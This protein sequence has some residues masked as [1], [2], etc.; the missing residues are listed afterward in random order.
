LIPATVEG[1]IYANSM[2]ILDLAHRTVPVAT[3]AR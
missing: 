3:L 2:V 1:L